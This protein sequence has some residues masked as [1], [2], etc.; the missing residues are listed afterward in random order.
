[1]KMTRKSVVLTEYVMVNSIF[2]GS[3]IQVTVYPRFV[4]FVL[5]TIEK[6]VYYL[7]SQV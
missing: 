1:M 3:F 7:P 4:W 2:T 5:E 6:I